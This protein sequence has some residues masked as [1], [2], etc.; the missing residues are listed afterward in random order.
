MY[1]LRAHISKIHIYIYIH[2]HFYASQV[3]HVTPRGATPAS[4][5]IF[6]NMEFVIH[7]K[8]NNERYQGTSKELRKKTLRNFINTRW[9]NELYYS[10]DFLRNKSPITFY[11]MYYLYIII[12]IIIIGEVE[13]NSN[14][15]SNFAQCVINY[16]FLKC[17]IS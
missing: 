1:A 14:Q 9:F 10:V 7:K 15:N 2:T 8:L 5:G 12:I 4:N 17:F 16:L 11:T 6:A 13:R 3:D